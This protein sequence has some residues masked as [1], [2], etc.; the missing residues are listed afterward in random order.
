[1]VHL[2]AAACVETPFAFIELTR[3]FDLAQNRWRDAARRVYRL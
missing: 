3:F 1:M 2:F